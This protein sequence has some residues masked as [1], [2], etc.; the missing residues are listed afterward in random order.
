MNRGDC[1]LFHG[2]ICSH[3]SPRVGISNIFHWF[4]AAIPPFL[5][6]SVIRFTLSLH[7]IASFGRRCFRTSAPKLGGGCQRVPLGGWKK[8]KM[9]GRS[10][11]LLFGDGDKGAEAKDRRGLRVC[12][13]E[14][15]RGHVSPVDGYPLSTLLPSATPPCPVTLNE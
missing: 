1:W 14:T 7:R 12:G 3:S 5:L 4:W 6:C 2:L 9:R 13:A 15:R 11:A 8:G 10:P